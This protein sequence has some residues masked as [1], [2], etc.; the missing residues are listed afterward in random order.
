MVKDF[1]QLQGFT[2]I[3][4]EE[5]GDTVWEFNIPEVYKKKQNVIR[6]VD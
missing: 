3:R 4:E 1:Y 5:N 6:V 2:K